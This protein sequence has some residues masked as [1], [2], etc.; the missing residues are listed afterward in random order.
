MLNPALKLFQYFSIQFILP[1][2]L[3]LLC[4][5]RLLQSETCI[6][7]FLYEQILL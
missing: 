6:S 1:S 3:R 5:V 4:T 2:P 7:A